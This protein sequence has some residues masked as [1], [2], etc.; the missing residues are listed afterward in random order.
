[1]LQKFTSNNDKVTSK[2]Q[3]YKRTFLLSTAGFSLGICRVLGFCPG[4]TGFYILVWYYSSSMHSGRV[5]CTS[6]SNIFSTHRFLVVVIFISVL[7]VVVL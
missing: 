1:M 3:Y 7:L 2:T 6:T 4:V 5:S